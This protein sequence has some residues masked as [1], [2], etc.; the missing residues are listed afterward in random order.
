[1]E[2]LEAVLIDILYS[3]YGKSIA[4]GRLECPPLDFNVSKM[5]HSYL[6]SGQSVKGKNIFSNNIDNEIF[7]IQILHGE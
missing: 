1:M 3:N 7:N 4:F 2:E 5:C 6:P